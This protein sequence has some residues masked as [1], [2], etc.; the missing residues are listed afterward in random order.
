MFGGA[1][2]ICAC[3]SSLATQGLSDL[4][5]AALKDLSTVTWSSSSNANHVSLAAVGPLGDCSCEG[6]QAIFDIRTRVAPYWVR[7]SG[8]YGMPYRK[9]SRLL[10][11]S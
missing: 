6:W 8:L 2:G 3:A 4:E 1:S 5:P 11:A 10:P 9:F 7:S